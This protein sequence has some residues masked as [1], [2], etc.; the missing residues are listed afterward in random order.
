M[1]SSTMRTTRTLT[2]LPCSLLLG[3]WGGLVSGLTRGG[4]GD[5]VRPG[6]VWPG[7]GVTM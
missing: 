1:H 4:G 7:G 2:V 3:G 5:Q 6:G